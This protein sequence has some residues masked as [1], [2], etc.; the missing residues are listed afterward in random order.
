MSLAEPG[1]FVRLFVDLGPG[2]IPLL[3]RL[4]LNEQQLKYVGTIL[5]GFERYDDKQQSDKS[6]GGPLTESASY[7]ESMSKRETEVL[8]L[9]AKRLTNKEIGE[10]LF[11]APETVKRHAHNI[12]D[13]LNVS[14]RRA[15]RAKA[16]GL[17]LVSD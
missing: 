3:N 2:I 7:L 1:G 8:E 12:F 4:E 14:D 15:A 6:A 5:A 10:R 16:I 9:L 17:G 11:I 13:K